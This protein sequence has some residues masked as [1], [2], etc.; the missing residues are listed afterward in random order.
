MFTLIIV[1]HMM[2]AVGTANPIAK[3]RAATALLN[4]AQ[5]EMDRLQRQAVNEANGS[6]EKSLLVSLM[7]RA[8]A[9]ISMAKQFIEEGIR[10][11]KDDIASTKAVHKL[12]ERAA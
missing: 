5:Q 12:A 3:I 9:I 1:N 11:Q 10:Q 8:S 6:P 2:S 7:A 4:N